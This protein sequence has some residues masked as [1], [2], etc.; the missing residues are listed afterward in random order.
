M[1]YNV[2]IVDDDPA[3]SDMIEAIITDCSKQPV[4]V[5]VCRNGTEAL[6]AR[7]TRQYDLITLDN[8]MTTEGEG[9]E[10][11]PKIRSLEDELKRSPAPVYLIS[12]TSDPN[13]KTKAKAAGATDFVKK[14]FE[15]DT[16][17]ALVS[18]YLP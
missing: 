16:I 15:I 2:L 10:T 5:T 13:I 18:K 11:L 3:I 12:A 8:D 17:E 7:G 9:L 1:V 6:A 4:N 14:P